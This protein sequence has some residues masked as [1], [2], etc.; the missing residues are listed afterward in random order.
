VVV[1]DGNSSNTGSF[2]LTAKRVTDP[3][4]CTPIASVSFA[5][6][7]TAGSLSSAGE[8]DCY[9]VP[10]VA[11]GD[12]IEIGADFENGSGQVALVNASGGQSCSGNGSCVIGGAGP[13]RLLV[14]GST[15]DAPTYSLTVRR[16]TNPQG[17]VPLGAPD[18]FSF[19][20]PRVTGSI[21]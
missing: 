19:T 8:I 6:A 14:S 21:A 20:A 9:S 2:Y 18:V 13:W 11:A 7:A 17:C 3:Q 16:V 5:A 1:E 4:G 12:R 10:D 15:T